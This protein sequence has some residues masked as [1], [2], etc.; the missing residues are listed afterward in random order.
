MDHQETWLGGRRWESRRTCWHA[1]LLS[2]WEED[3]DFA[4]LHCDSHPCSLFSILVLG[5][6]TWYA[7]HVYP[8][9]MEVFSFKHAGD[10]VRSNHLTTCPVQ[11]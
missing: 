10:S 11:R 1:Q 4:F 9:S 7:S 8:Y 2:S 5:V 3:N 6:S